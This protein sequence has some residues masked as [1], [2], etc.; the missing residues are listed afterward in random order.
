MGVEMERPQEA[1]RTQKGLEPAQPWASDFPEE[2]KP[3]LGPKKLLD[4]ELG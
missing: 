3:P 4:F 2:W 1:Q